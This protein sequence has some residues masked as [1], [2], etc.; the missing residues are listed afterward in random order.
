MSVFYR[1]ELMERW[2]EIFNAII[3]IFFLKGMRSDGSV[4]NRKIKVSGKDEKKY[5][6]GDSSVLSTKIY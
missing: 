5:K 4:L 1:G 3:K 2:S 6:K